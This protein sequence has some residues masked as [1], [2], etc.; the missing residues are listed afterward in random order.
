[1]VASADAET[2]AD[3]GTPLR[4]DAG[5]HAR[6]RV[7]NLAPRVGDLL[8][9]LDARDRDATGETFRLAPGT[10]TG[11]FGFRFE[12]ER[13]A[14]V[15]VVD[16]ADLSAGTYDLVVAETGT[17]TGTVLRRDTVRFGPA[18]YT[19]AVFGTP[20]AEQVRTFRDKLGVLH[21]GFARVRVVAVAP[22]VPA[23]DAR[24][25]DG[26]RLAAGLHYGHGG[27]HV[28]RAAGPGTLVLSAGGDD[29]ERLDLPL[30][31][32]TVTTVFVVGEADG[33]RPLRPVVAVTDAYLPDGR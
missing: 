7:A 20:G 10:V 21:P 19:L 30:A 23:L 26:D 5:T 9:T 11:A 18:S 3:T 16:P 27:R 15:N 24:I 14:P 25:E 2:R 1:V 17:G 28:E 6:V 12:G 22:D 31:P 13:G 8:V 33:G 4:S 32:D 29:A